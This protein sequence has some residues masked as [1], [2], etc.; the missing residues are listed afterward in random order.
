MN[1]FLSS[2]PFNNKSNKMEETV[3]LWADEIDSCNENSTA[4]QLS[5]KIDIW[6]V[7]NW[8]LSSY[9]EELTAAL[10]ILTDWNQWI[11]VEN[12]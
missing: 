5:C 9:C 2:E 12:S 6:K 10:K 3:N 8:Q 11:T 1:S 4:E 7:I